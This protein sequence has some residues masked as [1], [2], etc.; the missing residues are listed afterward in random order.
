MTRR[1]LMTR[2]AFNDYY[3]NVH[4]QKAKVLPGM[5]KYV[6]SICF[7]TP[8][9]DDPPFDAIAENYYESTEAMRSIYEASIWDEVRKDHP[10]MI[11]GRTMFLCEEHELLNKVQEGTRPIR[12]VA[13]LN[14]KD[15]MQRAA[16]KS[17][18]LDKHAPLALKAPNLL[19]YRASISLMSANGDAPAF[20]GMVEMWF[21]DEAAF[22]ESFRDP[23]WNRLRDDTY[24]NLAM[25]RL[26]FL[27][28]E[29]LVM[30]KTKDESRFTV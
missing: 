8:N 14:R 6:G 18:W 11:S 4:V 22:D 28:R 7:R 29:H 30:D 15:A 19:K 20:D 13:L 21:A 16:F 17:Y 9:G 3:I 2:E 12:Y 23:F 27:T 5:V 25:G 1:D 26:Q 24:S 10:N